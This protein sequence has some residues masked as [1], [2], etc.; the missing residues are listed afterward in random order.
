MAVYRNSYQITECV[1]D[2]VV[3][4]EQHGI[5]ITRL[6]RESNLPY[7]RMVKIIKKLTQS[8]LLVKIRVEGK[9]VFV[10]TEKGKL[11]LSEYKKFMGFAEDFGLEL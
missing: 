3:C 11:Y 4:S 2:T 5:P 10:I 6:M 7:S 9:Q 8:N 1:L